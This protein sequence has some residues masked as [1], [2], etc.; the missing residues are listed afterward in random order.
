MRRHCHGTAFDCSFAIRASISRTIP[1]LTVK[2]MHL[3]DTLNLV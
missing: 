2:T 1:S 3:E